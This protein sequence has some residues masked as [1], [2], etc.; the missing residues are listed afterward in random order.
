ML[1]DT[2]AHA[3]THAPGNTYERGHKHTQIHIIYFFFMATM[4][5]QLAQMLLYTYIACLVHFLLH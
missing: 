3:H 5:R 4:V 1:D 2:Y